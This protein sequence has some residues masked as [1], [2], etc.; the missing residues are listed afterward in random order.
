MQNDDRDRTISATADGEGRGLPFHDRLVERIRD[1][2]VLGELQAGARIPQARLSQQLGVS[3]TPLREALKYLASEGLVLLLPNRGARV[4][5]LT[6]EEIE[7]THE[8]LGALETLA[9]ARVV[10][11]ITDE[12]IAEICILHYQMVRHFSRGEP[13]EYL[14]LNQAIHQ[15]IV[16]ATGNHVLARTYATLRGRIARIRFVGNTL[17]SRWRDAVE[18]HEGILE[19]LRKRDA[20]LL[21]DRLCRHIGRGWQGVKDKLGDEVAGLDR[22]GETPWD[23]E[24]PSPPRPAREETEPVGE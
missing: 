8:V 20:D 17:G 5:K 16:D 22:A 19:A 2:I 6:A 7:Q 3:R 10:S 14:K 12:E 4:V 13:L 9:A 18:E 15:R 1:M 24:G 21:A 11:R 23:D